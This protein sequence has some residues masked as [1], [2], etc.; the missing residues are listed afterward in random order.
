MLNQKGNHNRVG[1]LAGTRYVNGDLFSTSSGI[2]LDRGELTLLRKAAEFDWRQV[3][4]TIFGSLLEGILG[5]E[6]RAE[7]GAHY[8]HEADIMK[9]V[10]PVIRPWRERIQAAAVAACTAGPSP[11]RRTPQTSSP[12]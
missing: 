7:L 12:A 4:P 1:N 9:V 5:E 6:R 3:D 10:P 8:T 2:M 11:R